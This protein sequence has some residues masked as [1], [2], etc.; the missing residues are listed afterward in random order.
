MTNLPDSPRCEEGTTGCPE[1]TE[2][3]VDGSIFRPIVREIKG[4]RRLR[5]GGHLE[6]VGNSTSPTRPYAALFHENSHIS[7]FRCYAAH[8][9]LRLGSCS[10]HCPASVLTRIHASSLAAR[11]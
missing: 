5:T 9:W 8:V 7:R 3:S 10:G 11:A 6:R 1:P 4:G 2:R